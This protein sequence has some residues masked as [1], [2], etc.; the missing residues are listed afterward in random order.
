MEN[1]VS[2]VSCPVCTLYMREG[3][4][5]Q[6]HLDT[7]P[8]D[9]V[10]AALVRISAGDNTGR[11]EN[12]SDIGALPT[13]TPEVAHS[14]QEPISGSQC[15]LPSSSHFTTAITYQQFLSSNGS[16][17][18]PIIPQYA[19]MPTI[20]AAPSASQS[21]TFMQMLYNPYMVQQ[22]QQFQ[23][24]S[25]VTSPSHQQPFMRHVVPSYP[26][27]HVAQPQVSL[28]SASVPPSVPYQTSDFPP[29]CAPQGL[30][31][32]TS[33]VISS[34]SLS[35]AV[36]SASSFSPS[37]LSCPVSSA[38]Y[39][40]PSVREQTANEQGTIN[41]PRSPPSDQ[42]RNIS[43]SNGIAPCSKQQREEETVTTDV[44]EE[45]L[46]P[47]KNLPSST[48]DVAAAYSGVATQTSDPQ[49][50]EEDQKSPCVAKDEQAA[51][52]TVEDVAADLQ[53]GVPRNE[54]VNVRV[55]KDLNDVAV[56]PMVQARD[57]GS[58]DNTENEYIDVRN[59]EMS[60]ISGIIRNALRIQPPPV[61]VEDSDEYITSDR[62]FSGQD[63]TSK[64]EAVVKEMT[65]GVEDNC[66]KPEETNEEGANRFLDLDSSEP[67]NIIEIDG[68]RIL[69]PSQFLENPSSVLGGKLPA[70]DHSASM[71]LRLSI[72]TEGEMQRSRETESEATPVPS[73]NI[74]TDEMMPPRGELSEQESV[75]GSD[76]SVWVQVS[77]SVC[78]LLFYELTN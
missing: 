57:S 19:S 54:S 58:E 10:I 73:L 25:S 39:S 45:N 52:V 74:Q 41:K 34:S 77:F 48:C 65:E 31:N 22:Q 40:Y 5:L 13:A 68:I 72:P 9:Q 47:D 6:S 29:E 16:A 53:Q 62:Q 17:S 51:A 14:S 70:D 61:S 43:V 23:L 38:S 64:E 69:V 30:Q 37:T 76:S 78:A 44:P 59:E 63:D 33:N 7:H 55:R 20:L 35:L 42:H 49:Y 26:T 3:V 18:N 2:P 36:S 24:L 8:K 56:S 71:P 1:G 4:T 66:E 11:K 46:F 21:T 75:G 67:V 12:Q 15:F 60:Q 50:E 32:T 27:H 28:A